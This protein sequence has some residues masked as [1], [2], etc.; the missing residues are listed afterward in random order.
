MATGYH[1]DTSLIVHADDAESN[2]LP[3]LHHL[4]NLYMIESKSFIRYVGHWLA[5]TT[6]KT[7]HL[8]RFVLNQAI[9]S[10]EITTSIHD[11][12]VALGQTPHAAGGYVEDP[13]LS[14]YLD[15]AT[16]IPRI[17]ESLCESEIA[18]S[19]LLGILHSIDC[20]SQVQTL[21]ETAL[22]NQTSGN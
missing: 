4:D 2:V 3:L 5:H 20:G 8:R 7:M 14:N 9:A 16:L 21:L 22:N 13:T 19:N 12:M 15:W 17:A 11:A 6:K 1:I 10:K 18:F